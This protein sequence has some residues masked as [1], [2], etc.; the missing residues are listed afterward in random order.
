MPALEAGINSSQI[1]LQFQVF[2][3]NPEKAPAFQT[4]PDYIA[5]LVTAVDPAAGNA[6]TSR[7]GSAATFSRRFCWRSASLRHFCAS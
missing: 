4:S 3:T 1:A 5:T 6:G 2:Q 7:F